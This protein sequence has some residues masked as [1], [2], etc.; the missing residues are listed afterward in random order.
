MFKAAILT[1]AIVQSVLPRMAKWRMAQIMGEGNR[2]DQILVQLQ[3][4]GNGAP[5]LRYFEAMRQ[6]RAKQVAFV[7]DEN[8]GFIFEPT[9]SCRMDDPVAVALE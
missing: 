7:I 5:D 2:F 1:H 4:T 6:A 3:V 8:L 9:E